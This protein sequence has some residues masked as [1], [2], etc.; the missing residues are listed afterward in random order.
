MA[1]LGFCAK[2]EAP[3]E[4]ACKERVSPPIGEGSGQ[5]AV[6]RKFFLIFGSKWAIFC[7]NILRSGKNG[8]SC[9]APKYA[10]GNE[11]W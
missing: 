10:T 8:A 5:D 11:M 6:P 3:W 7:S 4:V 2:F 1:Y 9:S